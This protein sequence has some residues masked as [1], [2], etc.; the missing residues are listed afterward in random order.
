MHLNRQINDYKL[1]MIDYKEPYKL[2]SAIA[3][4]NF[5]RVNEIFKTKT[6][7]QD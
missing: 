4:I 7:A 2:D 3:K 6:S 5:K 1:E